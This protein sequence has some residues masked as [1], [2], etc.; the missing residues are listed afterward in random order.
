MPRH[1][2]IG[3]HYGVK[4][5]KP[6]HV[7]HVPRGLSCGCICPACGARLVAKQGQFREHH[8]AHATGDPCP[9]ARETALH[10]A[11]KEILAERKEIVLPAVAV[12]FKHTRTVPIASEKRYQ[13]DS[14]K[15][16]YRVENIIP[17]VLAKIAGRPLLIEIRV[18][19]KVD[20]DK[21][22]RIQN[23]NM[24][25]IEIDL[26]DAPRDLL[27]KDLEELV[28]EA[29]SHKQWIHNVVAARQRKQILSKATTRPTTWRGF[30]QHVDGC[31]LRVRVWRGKPYANVIDDCT[32]CK[33]ILVIED[34]WLTCDA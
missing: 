21:L 18:T 34:G 22:K 20:D 10:L 28:V 13:L 9:Y 3:M 2:A 7:S 1:S 5:G 15:V 6:I 14:I 24:S 4:D 17:D 31:P 25:A 26:S 23:L 11:A 8:F 29:G 12:G 19:H 33:H 27:P 16:E 30:A 32:A